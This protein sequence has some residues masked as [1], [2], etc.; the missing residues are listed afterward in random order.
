MSGSARHRHDV[1]SGSARHRHEVMSGSARRRHE[2][3]SVCARHRLPVVT[4]PLSRRHM[5]V[6]M[7]P[8]PPSTAPTGAVVPSVAAP[9][10]AGTVPADRIPAP[11]VSVPKVLR[12]FDG[13]LTPEGRR[14]PG[15]HNSMRP[16]PGW[17]AA[18]RPQRRAPL[19]MILSAAKNLLMLSFAVRRARRL[20]ERDAPKM[21]RICQ[22]EARVLHEFLIIRSPT[23]P[24]RNFPSA[25]RANETPARRSSLVVKAWFG[26]T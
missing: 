15:R 21:W 12:L 6:V 5:V 24:A 4:G 19:T 9:I 3:M 7:P 1:M 8:P 20:Q 13:R 17:P 16:E 26:V 11:I 25:E 10:P 18:G 22:R 14:R 23:R 2:V